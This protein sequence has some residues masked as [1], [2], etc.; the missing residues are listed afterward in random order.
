MKLLVAEDWKGDIACTHADDG[1]GK[2]LCGSRT[3]SLNYEHDEHDFPDSG[4]LRCRR[5][6]ITRGLAK[7][8]SKFETMRIKSMRRL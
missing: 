4:C 5:I 7:P 6:L 8:L 1:T 2:P 3:N